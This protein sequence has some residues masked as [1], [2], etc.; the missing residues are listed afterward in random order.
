[1]NL[2]NEPFHNVRSFL[3][4]TVALGIGGL[5]LGACFGI[6]ENLTAPDRSPAVAQAPAE[7]PAAT[8]A[9]VSAVTTS[10]VGSVDNST[11]GAITTEEQSTI[12]VAKQVSP[13][14]VTVL[15]ERGL[16]SGVIIDSRKGIIL[17]NAHVVGDSRTVGIKLKNAK[18]LRGTVLG[19]DTMVDIAVVKV[20]ATNLPQ[21]ALGNS[22]KIEVG[23]NA[24]A[25]GNPLG[26]DQTVTT[27]VV[28]ALN[29]RISQDDVEGF[30]QTDAAINPGNSGGPL[31]DSQGRVIG[32]N[33]AVLRGGAEG[34]GFAVP[35]NVARD[36]ANQL[37]TTGRIR[38]VLVGIEYANN[39][40]QIAQYY[41]LPVQQGL[42]VRGV[43]RNAPGFV[44]GIRPGDIIT[45]IDGQSVDGS[46]TFQR[47]L[48]AKSP[49]DTVSVKVLR[50]NGEKTLRIRLAEASN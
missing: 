27:G 26:L 24:I 14:V 33:T 50:P 12:R 47:I 21:A 45:E 38:R 43:F 5:L 28:S 46:G 36:V 15:P 29:R 18:E 49:G 23:Q 22:D 25:I 6:G 3:A 11:V 7:T 41:D 34:L 31:L 42:I 19:K 13:A 2:N 39:N 9:T 16:G 4:K 10:A 32:I 35:I 40:P 17:T 1:M 30:I 37:V 8:P 44:A 20:T 48:R